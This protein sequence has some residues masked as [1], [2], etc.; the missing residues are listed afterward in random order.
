M[1]VK[2]VKIDHAPKFQRL[3]ISTRPTFFSIFICCML[4]FEHAFYCSSIQNL[5]KENIFGF[6]D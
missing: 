4:K 2:I 5:Q 6:A 3:E 1:G